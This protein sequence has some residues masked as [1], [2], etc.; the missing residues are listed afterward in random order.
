MSATGR[1]AR[2]QSRCPMLVQPVPRRCA[3]QCPQQPTTIMKGSSTGKHA[4]ALHLDQP[5]GPSR[6]PFPCLVHLSATGQRLQQL[7][8]CHA[9]SRWCL[10]DQCL[11]YRRG[12][13]LETHTALQTVVLPVSY[14]VIF[15]LEANRHSSLMAQQHSCMA[16]ALQPSS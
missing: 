14:T 1:G 7:P 2:P 8:A 3:S 11:R 5:P 4:S 10:P 15:M 6:S 13:Q 12:G 16:Q 9:A